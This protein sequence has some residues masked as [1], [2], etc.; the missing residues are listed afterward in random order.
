MEEGDGM[1]RGGGKRRFGRGGEG[2]DG[3]VWGGAVG[4]GGWVC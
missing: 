3:G 4:S 1:G 2:G